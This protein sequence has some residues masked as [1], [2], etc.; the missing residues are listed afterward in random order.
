MLHNI[1]SFINSILAPP[2]P[3]ALR[4]QFN[5]GQP[6]AQYPV[7]K[8]PTATQLHSAHE[9]MKHGDAVTIIGFGRTAG[10]VAAP[11]PIASP[12]LDARVQ[13]IPERL[14]RLGDKAGGTNF[15]AALHETLVVMRKQPSWRLKRVILVSDGEDNIDTTSVLPLVQQLA[16]MRVRIDGIA[17]G[18]HASMQ[19]L[20]V[21]SRIARGR[22]LR[23][24]NL[25]ELS[26]A[27]KAAAD[28][29]PPRQ[30]GGRLATI[31]LLV[32]MSGT[33]CERMPEE[34]GRRRI[35]VAVEALLAW[36]AYQRATFG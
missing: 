13:E 29:I 26:T 5:G 28:R 19:R 31:A 23:A 2:P 18:S 34:G 25:R 14:V 3:P 36:L 21:I 11:S 33:M 6:T 10:Y 35:D 22:V 30:S 7:R 1:R 9:Q 16:A 17:F 8:R 24:Q 15:A 4:P 32:D 20:E 12:Q 27:L